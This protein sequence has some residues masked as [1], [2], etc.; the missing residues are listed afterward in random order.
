VKNCSMCGTEKEDVV[1]VQVA[2]ATWNG[3]NNFA[4]VCEACRATKRFKA[5]STP[6]RLAGTAS[7]GTPN[8]PDAVVGALEIVHRRT[9]AVLSVIESGTL[10]GAVLTGV[11]LSGADLRHAVMRD[12]DLHR[13]DLHLADLAGADLRGADLRGVNLRGA[14][15]RGVDLRDARM[16]R[17]DLSHALY[18]GS[19][20]WPSGFDPRVSGARADK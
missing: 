17:A 3:F 5:N 11:V 19:T 15:L 20:R 6:K 2:P 8:A 12:A 13:A 14:D 9:G 7:S 1:V 18:D 4:E 10:T 16:N